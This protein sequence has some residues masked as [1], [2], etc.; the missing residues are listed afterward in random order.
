MGFYAIAMHFFIHVNF[1]CISQ[2]NRSGFITSVAEASKDSWA[3][4]Q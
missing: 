3:L 4:E 1:Q 2:E